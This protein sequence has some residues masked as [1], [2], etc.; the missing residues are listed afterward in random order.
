MP[1]ASARSWIKILRKMRLL[2]VVSSSVKRITRSTLQE[3]ASEL[4][5][6]PKNLLMLRRREVS[7]LWQVS[8]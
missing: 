8:Q 6:W 4:R 3:M 7:Y 2:L 5:R 1:R